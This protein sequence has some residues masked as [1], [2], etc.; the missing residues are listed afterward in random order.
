M[1]QV[2]VAALV[3]GL[4]ALPVL[5]ASATPASHGDSPDPPELLEDL[6]LEERD[7]LD[8]LATIEAE[9][10]RLDGQIAD[11]TA[12]LTEAELRLGRAE[13]EVRAAETR[14]RESQRDLD[15]ATERLTDEAIRIY[16]G[17]SELRQHVAAL[18]LD[19][20]NVLDAHAA[21]TY[22]EALL[23][24][25]DT[26]V[27]EYR[28]VRAAVAAAEAEAEQRRDTIAVEHRALEADR[29]HLELLRSEQQQQ[30]AQQQASLRELH[31]RRVIVEAEA[32]SASMESDAIGRELQARQADQP[33]SPPE[34]GALHY[35]VPTNDE[36]GSPYGMRMHPILG[37][38]RLHR[39][40]DFG[41]RAGEPVVAAAGGVVA[42]AGARGGY[43]NAVVIDHGGKLAT[44]YGHNSRLEVTAGDQV[45]AGQT[46][47]AC[48]STGLS[49]GPHSHFETRIDGNP[50]DPVMLLPTR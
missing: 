40:A 48:G 21:V 39:G 32:A 16:V 7:L 1:R 10:A 31:N 6:S 35:P 5:P 17:G 29:Q 9:I 20:H 22:G 23:D 2:L 42:I 50:I 43:G 30:L 49:T 15:G 38:A 28:R 46:I 27:D 11:I 25:Q 47:A 19:T 4:C 36:V 44:L 18:L 33:L 24:Q 3:L 41:C 37:Y 13:D 45:E 12:S 14:S 8:S 26:V 34:A